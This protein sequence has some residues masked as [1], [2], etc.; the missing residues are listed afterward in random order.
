[1]RQSLSVQVKQF[2]LNSSLNG[3]KDLLRRQMDLR[4]KLCPNLGRETLYII[5]TT[6]V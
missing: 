1:M 2:C 6:R 3:L 5:T 4:A